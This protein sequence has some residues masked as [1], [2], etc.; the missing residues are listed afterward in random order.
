MAFTVLGVGHDPRILRDE[1]A[2]D[3]RT[4]ASSAMALFRKGQLEQLE[5]QLTSFGDLVDLV[6]VLLGVLALFVRLFH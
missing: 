1:L 5:D 6:L 4:E 3:S 2:L